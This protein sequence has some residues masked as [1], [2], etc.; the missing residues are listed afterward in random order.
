MGAWGL[1]LP[2]A[3]ASVMAAIAVW[4]VQRFAPEAAGSGIPHLKA[5]L[6]GRAAMRPWRLLPVKFVS[7]ALGIGAGMALGREGPTA[8]MGGA[9]ATLLGRGM[10][11]PDA[12]QRRFVAVGAAAG[13][14][15]AFNAP[16]AATVFVVEE[17]RRTDRRTPIL[18]LIAC[19]SADVL[20]RIAFGPAYI[21]PTFHGAP[22]KL[23]SLHWACLIGVLG[24]L[25]GPL[26]NQSLLSVLEG[27]ATMVRRRPGFAGGTVGLVAGLSAVQL[28]IV[29]GDGE[30][31]IRS[32][33][34]GRLGFTTAAAFFLIRFCLTI[35]SFGS[36]AAGGIFAPLLSI[37]ATLGCLASLSPPSSALGWD[38][39]LP[40][41]VVVGM[42]AVL[43]AALHAPVTGVLLVVEITGDLA[44]APSL[45][46]AGA[47]AWTV[48]RLCGGRP[49][50]DALL[51]R[52]FVRESSR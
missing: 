20:T 48:S 10:S 13:L 17:L 49:I 52:K 5:V 9:I 44:L 37:G 50:Y 14:A 3:V 25:V 23:N 21:F 7:G 4:C 16:I 22:P 36:G 18:A 39:P 28:P 8:Q 35:A 2:P 34:L 24:G 41:A 42:A 30:Q 26:F 51:E 38:F 31:L 33:V 29:A 11:L 19:V 46:A 40:A 43:I 15:A 27:T 47:L 1:C 12:M 32:A 45:V 6:Q